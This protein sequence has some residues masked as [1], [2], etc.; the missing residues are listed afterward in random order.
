MSPRGSKITQNHENLVTP[1][2]DNPRKKDFNN[3][4]NK[5]AA[6]WRVMRAAHWIDRQRPKYIEYAHTYTLNGAHAHSMPSTKTSKKEKAGRQPNY[7]TDGDLLCLLQRCPH[8]AMYNWA[9]W[10]TKH[11]K[12]ASSHLPQMCHKTKTKLMYTLN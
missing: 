12:A 9:K 11:N 5:D 1:N 8:C 7:L 6:R 4:R 3:S 10:D 2:Q